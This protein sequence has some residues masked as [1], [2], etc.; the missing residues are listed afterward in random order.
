MSNE[1]L[2]PIGHKYSLG[3]DV[4]VTSPFSRLHLYPGTIIGLLPYRL[5]APAYD[6][7]V[8][9]EKVALSERSLEKIESQQTETV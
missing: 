9:G 2:P 5:V 3:D 7:L 8:G 4:V 1:Y 6:V